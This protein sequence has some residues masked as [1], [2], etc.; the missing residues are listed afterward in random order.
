M[1][2]IIQT[3][4]QLLAVRVQ[5][6]RVSKSKEYNGSTQTSIIESNSISDKRAVQLY[7]ET[8][9]PP[10]NTTCVTDS[11]L[12]SEAPPVFQ[13]ASVEPEPSSHQ[14][15]CD[16]LLAKVLQAPSVETAL[17]LIMDASPIDTILSNA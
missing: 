5:V 15:P 16:E 8:E 17:E 14:R 10:P 3:V 4:F 6:Y 1:Q 11:P 2:A 13:Q 12:D 9:T 7:L